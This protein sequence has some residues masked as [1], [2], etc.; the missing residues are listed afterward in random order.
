MSMPEKY[1]LALKSL[2]E[3][4][5]DCVNKYAKE[6]ESRPPP[7]MIYHY[8]NDTGLRGILESKTLWL[9]SVFDLNDPSE[10]KHGLTLA[11]DRLSGLIKGGRPESTLLASLFADFARTGIGEAGYF[12]C[13]SFSSNGDEL[14]QWRAY[15]DNGRGFAL[16]FDAGSIELDFARE[17]CGTNW[18]FPLAY[19]D[20]KLAEILEKLALSALESVQVPDQGYLKME[21]GKEYLTVI[22]TILSANAIFAASFFKHAAYRNESEYRFLSSFGINKRPKNRKYRSRPYSL[23]EYLE[24]QWGEKSLDALKKIV[25]G[26]AAD[27]IKAEKFVDDCLRAT[28]FSNGK[29]E[30]EHSTIPY[31][32]T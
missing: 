8:T 23:A 17:S 11:S 31:R 22:G 10:L 4:T 30:I 13:C 25:I 29:V 24:Y 1:R 12:Y 5:D 19:D 26:P 15:A 9:T 16:A 14:G 28:G 20:A 2:S 3:N 6:I 21:W 7:K 27:R 32:S 18:A